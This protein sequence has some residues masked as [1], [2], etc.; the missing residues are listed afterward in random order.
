MPMTKEQRKIALADSGRTMTSIAE[1][2]EVTLPHV[3]LVVSGERRSPRVEE[4]VAKA[5]G[6]PVE[7][8]FDPVQQPAA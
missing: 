2:L 5:I 1:E 6:R 7:E 3:S 8:V 4:A